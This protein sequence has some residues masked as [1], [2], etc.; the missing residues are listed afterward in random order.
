MAVLP[1]SPGTAAM[2][3]ALGEEL[4]D[5]GRFR[6]WMIDGPEGEPICAQLFV[7]AGGAVAYWNGGFD[8]GWAEHS[9]GVLAILAA[10]EEAIGRGDRLLDLGGGEASYKDRLA[11]E[12]RPVAWIVSYPRGPRYAL[13][14]ARR[15]PGK[16]A[17]RA[18]NFLRP[19]LG[20]DRLNRIRGR[21]R[22]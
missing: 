18:G 19:K 21:L 12:D 6:L 15:L 8:E 20:G 10:I 2:L 7:E 3:L 16:T 22:R 4:I 13:A 17:R 5:A 1:R 11:D 9:P 14:W